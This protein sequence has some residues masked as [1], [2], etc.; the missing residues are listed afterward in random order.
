MSTDTAMYEARIAAVPYS[1]R[2]LPHLLTYLESLLE[3]VISQHTLVRGM[4]HDVEQGPEY[5][6]VTER[7]RFEAAN[8]AE[9]SIITREAGEKIGTRDEHW[10]LMGITVERVGVES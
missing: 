1:G 5:D 4:E 7:L 6:T 9:A 3:T 2:M 10:Q 8:D